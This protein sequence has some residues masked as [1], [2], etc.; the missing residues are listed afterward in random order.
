MSEASNPFARSEPSF[1][2]GD[3]PAD[4]SPAELQEEIAE[5]E[6]YIPEAKIPATGRGN[7]ADGQSWENPSA[8]QLFRA[9]RRRGKDVESSDAASVANAHEVVTQMTWDGIMQFEDM[10]KDECAEPKLARFQGTA[11][12]LSALLGICPCDWMHAGMWG[13]TSIYERI[14]D[15]K[16]RFVYGHTE[17]IK[18]FDRHD[19]WVD[20]CGREVRYII[21][22]YTFEDWHGNMGYSVDVN[23]APTLHG[24]IDLARFKFR[25]W[26]NSDDDDEY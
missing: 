22:Y 17:G 12:S 14:A 5:H 6:E 2:H 24:F 19:W 1:S 4:L 10:H 16:A 9:L 25:Q 20:R 7:S 21:D 15:L 3:V 26:M 23:P 8:S 13:H 11:F 18:S